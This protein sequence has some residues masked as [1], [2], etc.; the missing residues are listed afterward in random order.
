MVS[1]VCSKG[2][3]LLVYYVVW[4]QFTISE[5][6]NTNIGKHFKTLFEFISL[7]LCDVIIYFLQQLWAPWNM[8]T[9]L[10]INGGC[11]T[12]WKCAIS[13]DINTKFS[14]M[15]KSYV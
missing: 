2:V 6:C 10:A 14:L 1:C 13:H 15:I 8:L 11:K 12:N 3:L 4:N 5:F 9:F 7:P